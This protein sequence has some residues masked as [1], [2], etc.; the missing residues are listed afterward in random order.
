[1]FTVKIGEVRTTH[2]L[3]LSLCIASSLKAVSSAGTNHTRKKNK[4]KN[5][6]GGG[7]PPPRFV[8]EWVFQGAVVFSVGENPRGGAKKPAGGGGVLSA[9]S[10]GRG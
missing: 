10:R 2:P 8:A 4:V 6:R 9:N 7:I 3:S 1:V 5:H